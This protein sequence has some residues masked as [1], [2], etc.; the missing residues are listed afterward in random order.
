M[1]IIA[2]AHRRTSGQ[3]RF[4]SWRSSFEERDSSA[5]VA[6]VNQNLARRMWPDANPI[7]RRINFFVPGGMEGWRTVVGVVAD[8]RYRG[9]GEESRPE[10]H[11][12]EAQSPIGSMRS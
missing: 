10:I 11:V 6:I 1:P 3:W 9:F 2:A 12:P 5:L 7:G 4:L 8:V